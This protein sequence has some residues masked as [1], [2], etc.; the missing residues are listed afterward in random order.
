[1]E[2]MCVFALPE[3]QG[4]RYL[5][6]W[7]DSQECPNR[8]GGQCPR[9][10]PYQEKPPQ[11]NGISLSVPPAVSLEPEAALQ[12]HAAAINA[13]REKVGL[14]PLPITHF[15]LGRAAEQTETER[16]VGQPR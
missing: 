12:A 7:R 14:A 3:W 11:P 5:C 15:I 16:R 6:F 8:F 2:A 4:T 10:M 9:F 1:M 13:S